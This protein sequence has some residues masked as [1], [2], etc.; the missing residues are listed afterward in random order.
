[1]EIILNSKCNGYKIKTA[2]FAD[3]A[4][5]AT[6]IEYPDESLQVLEN[7]KNPNSLVEIHDYWCSYTGVLD[8]PF[9]A[10]QVK[11]H[12]TSFSLRVS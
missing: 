3:S 6:M 5:F 1:M 7:F 4:E 9:K 8:T 12:L 2:F 10:S 11:K